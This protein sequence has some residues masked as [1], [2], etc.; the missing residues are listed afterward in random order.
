[1]ETYFIETRRIDSFARHVK[2]I[3]QRVDKRTVNATQQLYDA[4]IYNIRIGRF[5]L[6]HQRA[7]KTYTLDIDVFHVGI[8]YH[9][10]DFRLMPRR[11]NYQ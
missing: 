7:T 11:Q 8:F 5:F 3:A 6:T 10:N 2:R 4:I 1:M 9:D